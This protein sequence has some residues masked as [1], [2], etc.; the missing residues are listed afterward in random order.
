[1]NQEN[2]EN[3]EKLEQLRLRGLLTDEEF[4]RSFDVTI[5]NL[6]ASSE[7]FVMFT[8]KMNDKNGTLS[9]LMTY[10]KYVNSIEKTLD[11]LEK[12]GL[13]IINYLYGEKKMYTYKY[14]NKFITLDYFI[15]N[16]VLYNKTKYRKLK[17]RFHEKTITNRCFT[18][19]NF[20][21]R[22]NYN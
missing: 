7:E 15:L 2:T 20:N 13:K 19:I 16:D 5:Q 11:N 10:P 1:M 12:S 14:R 8:S 3:I 18:G 6:K 17:I 9:K 22:T 4:A 21:I